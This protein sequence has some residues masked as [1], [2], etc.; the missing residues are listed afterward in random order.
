[1]STRYLPTG[2]TLP[3]ITPWNRPFF[4][5]AQ[6][7]IQVCTSCEGAQHP[8]LDFCHRCQGHDLDYRA[9]AGTGVI[10]NFSV[11]HHAGSAMLKDVLPYNVVLVELSD[12]PG[13][14]VLGNVVDEDWHE[15]LQ[16]GAEVRV[17]FAEVTDPD[18]GELLALPQWR[19]S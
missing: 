19:L 18:T 1:M 9:A 5:A 2:W 4:T 3:A 8:P 14:L 12:F 11:V 10:D 6:L 15:R 16:V 7:L 17:E 13:L